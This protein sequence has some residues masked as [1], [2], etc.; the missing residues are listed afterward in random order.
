MYTTLVSTEELAH[1]LGDPEWV[2][3]DCRFT[4]TDTEAGRRAYDAGHIP[5]AR[6]A[7]LDEDLS[8][9]ITPASGRHPLP[10]PA[11]LAAKLGKWGMDGGKQ[12]VAYDD[13]FGAMACRL[14]WL[15]RWLGHEN[16]ALLNG[17][18]PKW[19]REGRPVT[20]ERPSVTPSTFAAQPHDELWVDA[21]AVARAMHQG[22]GL[23]LDARAEERFSGEREPLDKVAG[24]IPGAVNLPF[25]DALDLGGTLQ[26]VGELRQLF[27]DTL[28][29]A[30]P[31]R[32]IHMCGS[33]VTA[34]HN[35][36]AM[37]I[38]ASPAGACT[39]APGASGLLTAIGR[40]PRAASAI[41][42]PR[43]LEKFLSLPSVRSP[44]CRYR[45]R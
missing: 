26:S 12:V 3:F 5:G 18:F 28:D 30:D 29:G 8:S 42:A 13:S 7:H 40:W 19:R 6:Y 17:G 23:I 25:D 4:L 2:V 10:D 38:A 35:M 24:H 31:N 9:P 21:A 11:V 39:R 22:H 14:W 45:V 32:V 41:F 36:L 43:W 33:G 16:V 44:G 1:H 15:L 37:E 34:C 20:K 27:L